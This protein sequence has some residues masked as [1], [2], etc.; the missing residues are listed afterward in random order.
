MKRRSIPVRAVHQILDANANRAREGLR[1]VEEVFRF[2]RKDSATTRKLKAMRREIVLILET[3]RIAAASLRESRNSLQDPGRFI[4][5]A[6]E[7]TRA[8]IED[9]L[10]ANL[11]RVG[12][13]LRV[14]EE[15]LKLLDVRAAL[16]FKQLRFRFY[17]LEKV[18]HKAV[19]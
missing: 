12:E 4:H 11:H 5:G 19:V 17:D 1:V 14:L 6:G 3:S 8:S 15:F 13:A 9:I 10:S 18:V 7:M 16:R 2:V